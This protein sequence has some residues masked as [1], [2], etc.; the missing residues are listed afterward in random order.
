MNRLFS[1]LSRSK[2]DQVA[3]FSV[4]NRRHE[5]IKLDLSQS[6]MLWQLGITTSRLVKVT[7]SICHKDTYVQILTGNTERSLS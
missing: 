6:A 3:Q 4:V 2:Y 1:A 5:G 7:D